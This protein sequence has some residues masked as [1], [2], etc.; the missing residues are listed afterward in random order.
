MPKIAIVGDIFPQAP[1]PDSAELAEVRALLRSGD[2]AFGNLETPVS[3]RG[4][5]AEKWIN[6]RMPPDLLADVRELGFDI[7]T[8]A[9]NHMLDF[10]EIAFR[11]TLDHLNARGLSYVGAGPDID[12]AWRAQV[13]RL[14]EFKVAFL[15]AASTLS[16]GAAAAEGKPG[17]AP[18]RVSESYQVDPHASLE[19]PG[20]APYVHTCAWREDLQRAIA[21][22]EAARRQAD[23]VMLAMHWGVP[24]FW[25]SRFQDGL[26]DYQIDVGHAP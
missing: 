6:M 23:F 15:G 16:P 22:V 8:L 3:T 24:P 26:A 20:S 1:L 10:G 13:V 2:I 17:V 7:L 5:P 12:A 19:Q 9:N 14:G 11:D 25:R 18:I 21:A 4:T